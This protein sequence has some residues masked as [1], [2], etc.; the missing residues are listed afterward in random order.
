[1]NRVDGDAL[2]APGLLETFAAAPRDAE[3]QLATAIK[4]N[5]AGIE[6]EFRHDNMLP[7][8]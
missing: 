2:P 3:S 8:Q 6:N 4:N 1:L 7:L 5:L